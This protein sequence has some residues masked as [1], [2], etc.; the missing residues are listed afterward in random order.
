LGNG[1]IG[2]YLSAGTGNRIGTNADGVS[3]ATEGNLISGNPE[4]GIYIDSDSNVVAG[5]KV[6]TNADGTAALP[7]GTGI[8]LVN[9]NNN[10]IGGTAA[11]ACNLIAYNTSDGVVISGGAGN[12]LLCN[13]IFANGGYDTNLA[14]AGTAD[15]GGSS[16]GSFFVDA[17]ATLSVLGGTTFGA[18]TSFTGG[19]NAAIIIVGGSPNA[20]V[21][22]TG[23]MTLDGVTFNNAGDL[24]LAVGPPFDILLQ[25]GATLHNLSGATIGEAV[26]PPFDVAIT[27]DGTFVNDGLVNVPASTFS[28]GAGSSTGKFK[29]AAG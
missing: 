14:N 8:G 24:V 25:G 22:V 26:G 21:Q 5:N 28:V 15:V 6:G 1:R 9:A 4:W 16:S 13:S 10:L 7:N 23:N 12:V 11:A 3:D 27:G 18:G 20:P 29:V 17:G 19:G 2:I